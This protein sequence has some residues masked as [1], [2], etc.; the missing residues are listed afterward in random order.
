M[1]YIKYPRTLHLP[2]SEGIANDDK[3]M[4]D[5]SP[6]EGKQ[7]VVTEKM[8]GEAA[9]L[10]HDYIHARSLTMSPHPSRTW[11]KQFHAQI[12]HAIPKGWR[13]CGENVFATHS[14]HYTNLDSYFFGFSI[15]TEDNCA[16]DWKETCD[17]FDLLGITPVPV[18]FIGVFRESEIRNQGL[19]WTRNKD[20]EGYVVRL[21]DGFAFRDFQTS[22]AK[23][24]RKNHVQTDEHWMHKP[25]IPNGLRKGG[26]H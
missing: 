5:T 10:Y 13:V 26:A 24:V 1:V 4:L 15:W 21:Y 8:D 20:V 18:L 11:I 6:L 2:W 16:L 9:T 3:V 23:W 25:I 22:V 7:V 19:A 12:R 17:Y 14:I